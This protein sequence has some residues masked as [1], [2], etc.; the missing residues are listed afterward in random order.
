MAAIKAL[1]NHR[2]PRDYAAARA[3]W[4]DMIEGTHE[5]WR[6][7]SSPKRE[8]VRS[9]LNHFN[10]EAVKR[11]RPS[12]RFDFGGASI[13]N[14]FLTGARLF[15]GSLEAAIYLLSSVCAVP[16]TTAVLPALNT[17]FAHHI[18]VGLA[19]GT[20]IAG[21]ND[22]S[23]PNVPTAASPVPDANIYSR[24][25]VVVRPQTHHSSLYHGWGGGGSGGGG[26]G[27]AAAAAAGVSL[28]HRLHKRTNE[29]DDEVE[30]ANLPGTL[31]ALRRPAIEFSKTGEEDLPA[32]IE[33]LWYINPYGEEIRIPAN[34]RVLAAVRGATAVV[35]SIGSLFTSLVPSLVL[36]GVGDALAATP[37]IRHKILILNGSHDRE[38]GPSG[39]PMT[40]ED[41]VAAIARACQDSRAGGGGGGGG[42]SGSATPFREDDYSRYVT[43]VVHLDAPGAPAVDKRRM[44]T[45]GIETVRLY[46]RADAAGGGGARYD[47]TALAQALE[48][49]VGRGGEGRRRYTFLG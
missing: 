24:S 6:D 26:G 20:V 9:L 23:H 2:L 19:D 36:R 12:S 34:P 49:I 14:L 25:Q 43:H 15:T 13:G 16:D 39:S 41:F 10:L 11:V 48:A 17:N 8:L 5:L 28:G 31:S 32:R 30:D 21:Q 33:R 1:F 37:T 29:A 3:Q 44:A 45:L 47:V 4:L 35:F 46:G 40:A 27:A 22:I 42:G 38:S 18:A 7:V